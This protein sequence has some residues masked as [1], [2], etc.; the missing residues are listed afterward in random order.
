M[1][2]S[3]FANPTLLEVDLFSTVNFTNTQSAEGTIID[4]TNG[5][6][7]VFQDQSDPDTAPIS[8]S[9]D[10]SLFF[11]QIIPRTY[12]GQ[13]SGSGSVFKNGSGDLTMSGNNLAFTGP[14]SVL[15]G[16]LFLEGA[17]GGNVTV[18]SS[19]RIVYSGPIL[20]DLNITSGT[21]TTIGVNALQVGGNYSQAPNTLYIANVNS[22]GQSS[23]INM[24]GIANIGGSVQVDASRGVLTN[25]TYQILHANGGV[26]GTY[27]LINP[28]PLLHV[29]ITYD[30]NNVY[31]S[32]GSNFIA[33]AETPNEKKVAVQLDQLSPTT[34][35]EVVIL[36]ALL[37]LTSAEI[38]KALNLLSGEPY[39]N[40][41]LANVYGG[42][43]FSRKIF[44]SVRTSINPCS[45]CEGINNWVSGGGGQ[46]FQIGN[47]AT[48]GF[49][50]NSYDV[51]VGTHSCFGDSWLLGGALGFDSDTIHSD[52]QTKSMLKTGTVA[53]Y[54]VFQQKRGY[55]LTD[56]IA[57]RTWSDVHRRIDFGSIDRTAHSAPHLAYG[58]FDLQVGAD[59]GNCNYNVKPYAAGSAELYH[60]GNVNE[61][62]AQSVDL[63]MTSFNKWLASSQLGFHVSVTAKQ[64]VS[65][66]F[67]L[68]WQHYFGNLRVGEKTRFENFG[69]PFIIQGSKRGSDGCLVTLY[70]ITPVAKAWSIY[71][72]AEGEIW[73]DWYAYE[74]DGGLSY[75][76]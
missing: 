31:L 53:I 33:V 45:R 25:H 52:L 47:Q 46:G 12:S 6:S 51:N 8:I 15:N 63:S 44:N 14:L 16:T 7:V 37:G 54:S 19:A 2:I 13:F 26:F 22:A 9:N 20:G 21:I 40:L 74:V 72:G 69:A 11:S 28:Y 38:S 36:N 60:Q 59:L 49:Y 62:G 73:R 27:A 66:D 39:S 24:A 3:V 76:W 75:K 57:A 48:P 35:D 1:A 30:P 5:S 18:S 61:R 71:L 10:S 41:V 56:L 23:L 17:Y 34:N 32:F 4:I 50:L 67:D 55:I 29:F 68:A 70:A 43:R 64:K 58:R 42:S 65:F